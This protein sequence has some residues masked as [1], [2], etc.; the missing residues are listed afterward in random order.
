MAIV[1]SIQQPYSVRR[2]IDPGSGMYCVNEDFLVTLQQWIVFSKTTITR[3]AS[4]AGFSPVVQNC[5]NPTSLSAKRACAF[6]LLKLTGP[7]T[8]SI[9]VHNL[10]CRARNNT[11][12][13]TPGTM[14]PN[15]KTLALLDLAV[16]YTPQNTHRYLPGISGEICSVYHRLRGGI[17]PLYRWIRSR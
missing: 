2:P 3:L 11:N 12:R 5:L 7:H 15:R 13:G 6:K 1:F 16:H 8:P 10:I 9:S 14:C 4:S 17:R